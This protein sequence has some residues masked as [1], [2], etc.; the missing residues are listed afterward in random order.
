[1]ETLETMLLTC[2]SDTD[3]CSYDFL[4][5]SLIS[6]IPLRVYA[7]IGKRK[8]VLFI[9]GVILLWQ[10]AIALYAMSQSSKG[11][12]QLALLLSPRASAL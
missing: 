9:C 3:V 7:L 4:Y 8:P 10:W 5:Y 6:S 11:T 2:T 12:D 1:M